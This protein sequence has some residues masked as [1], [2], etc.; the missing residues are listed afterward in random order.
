L[1]NKKERRNYAVQKKNK[2]PLRTFG[3][4]VV[5]GKV[6][7]GKLPNLGLRNGHPHSFS[8]AQLAIVS[9]SLKVVIA[10]TTFSVGGFTTPAYPAAE[11]N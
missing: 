4:G 5:Q 6:E 10:D 11:V 9:N 7:F 3:L 8:M 1:E 2:S